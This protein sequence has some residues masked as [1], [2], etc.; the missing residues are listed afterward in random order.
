M[1]DNATV[2]WALW[3]TTV[4][5]S[6][7]NGASSTT[8]RLGLASGTSDDPL[9][10][11]N[12]GCTWTIVFVLSS[13]ICA[14]AVVVN[15]CVI[16]VIRRTPEMRR[17]PYSVLMINLCASNAL[18]ALVRGVL[19]NCAM[20]MFVSRS[21]PVCYVGDVVYTVTTFVS[22]ST[23]AV[24]S[25]DRFLGVA[26]HMRYGAS[27]TT[28]KYSV[29]AVVQWLVCAALGVLPVT[30]KDMYW[31][32]RR[33]GGCSYS[34]SG[35]ILWVNSIVVYVPCALVLLF[36][37]VRI[38]MAIRRL[39][40]AASSDRKERIRGI[41]TTVIILSAFVAT[42]LPRLIVAFV[43]YQSNGGRPNRVDDLGNGVEDATSLFL[44]CNALASPII[45]SLTNRT[46]KNRLTRISS[47]PR[48]R[49]S[50]SS[51]STVREP[52]STPAGGSTLV[53][54]KAMQ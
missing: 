53:L 27:V 4:A 8:G 25:F 39:T 37:Y 15:A 12:V 22:L 29:F 20:Q 48:R 45:Y 54:G 34:N 3:P 13:L 40:R 9:P 11:C 30:K 33:F 21:L 1:Q 43:M 10:F 51:V 7:T 32:V 5:G 18:T 46:F 50:I 38:L 41:R 52:C 31:C 26:Y 24:M 17:Q 36:S 19:S 2:T 42:T 47:S 6:D 14:V 23:I 28:L 16:A 44:S 35:Y 49:Y